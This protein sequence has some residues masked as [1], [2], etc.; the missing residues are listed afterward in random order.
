MLLIPEITTCP[1]TCELPP[2]PAFLDPT[3]YKPTGTHKTHHRQDLQVTLVYTEM[4]VQG[5][6]N[7]KPEIIEYP[8]FPQEY[9]YEVNYS[10]AIMAL[11]FELTQHCNVAIRK[12][13][14]FLLDIT[15]NQL[16]ISV[17]TVAK[18][19][20]EFARKAEG[21]RK[22]IFDSIVSSKVIMGDFIF[23]RMNGKQVAVL[24]STT[25]EGH[26]LY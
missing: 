19:P 24:I 11:L 9:C 3:R 8:F 15:R 5:Y 17:G 4:K 10:G 22:E 16:D 2:P 14:Q 18:L 26:S 1:G 20:R 21:E 25:P 23:A 12:A 13:R 6:K 7:L